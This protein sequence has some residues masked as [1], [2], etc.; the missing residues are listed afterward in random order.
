MI[1]WPNASYVCVFKLG[2]NSLEGRLDT[3][4]LAQK[5]NSGK[6]AESLNSKIDHGIVLIIVLKIENEQFNAFTESI[7][8]SRIY[9]G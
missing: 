5:S 2:I 7:V 8:L 9:H 6:L 4:E 3:L 1:Q